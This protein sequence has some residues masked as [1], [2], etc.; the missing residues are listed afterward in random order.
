MKRTIFTLGCIAV[1]AC[2]STARAATYE[3]NAIPTSRYE[4]FWPGGFVNENGAFGV[5]GGLY[6]T[7]SGD[8]ITLKTPTDILML[9]HANNGYV[10]FR[11]YAF[12]NVTSSYTCYDVAG[13]GFTGSASYTK[14]GAGR[15]QFSVTTG[16]S[17]VSAPAIAGDGRIDDV[18]RVTGTLHVPRKIVCDTDVPTVRIESVA[19]MRNVDVWGLNTYLKDGRLDLYAT[20]DYKIVSELGAEFIPSTISV[21]GTVGSDL[22]TETTLNVKTVGGARLTVK[23]PVVDSVYYNDNGAWVQEHNVI[24][25]VSDGTTVIR[26]KIKVRSAQPGAKIISVP[27][28]LTLD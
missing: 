16:A 2:V 6:T 13:S 9:V 28:E 11:A 12:L 24:E 8:S 4:L 14:N 25:S 1:C 22:I 23:W 5:A 27:V 10:D 26:Q 15:G 17:L 19:S 20:V 18:N 7:Q 3:L 21:I